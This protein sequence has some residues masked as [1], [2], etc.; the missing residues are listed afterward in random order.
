MK[1]EILSLTSQ[2]NRKKWNQATISS[3]CH[4][5]IHALN[6]VMMQCHPTKVEATHPIR[7]GLS[8]SSKAG[9][10]HRVSNK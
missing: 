10:E 2:G 3:L 1:T 6:L 9:I 8:S 5:I 4:S 7:E